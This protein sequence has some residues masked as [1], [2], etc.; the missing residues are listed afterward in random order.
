MISGVHRGSIVFIE[1]Y[2]HNGEEEYV[3]VDETG[4]VTIWDE[5]FSLKLATFDLNASV[6]AV[7]SR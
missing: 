4:L 7:T 3:V 6:S 1:Q 5:D 2:E